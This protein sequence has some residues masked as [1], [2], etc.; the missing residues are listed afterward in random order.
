MVKEKAI[1]R[2]LPA[3]E[4]LGS[5]EVVCT[6]KTG[7]ITKNEL[8]VKEVYSTSNDNTHLY[9]AFLY[10]NNVKDNIGDPLEVSLL[11][12]LKDNKVFREKQGNIIKEYPFSSERKM[13]SIYIN[14]NNE[15][16]LYAKGAYESIIEKCRY[17]LKHNEVI[18]LDKNIKEE[19]E[20]KLES[21]VDKAYRVIAFAYKNDDKEQ[22]LIFLGLVGFIDPPRENISL[23]IELM[24][25]AGIKIV[26]ITGDA[27]KTAYQIAKEVGIVKNR[28]ECIDGS[29][30]DE[31][32][33]KNQPLDKYKVF[34]RVNP[35]HKVKIVEYYKKKNKVVA[36]TGDGVNDAPALKMADVGI[37]MGNGSEVAKSS[38]NIILLDNNFKT[39]EK[40][41]EEGRNIFINIKKAVLFLLSSNLGEVL[42]VVIFLLLRLP[43]PLLSI[44]ILW[45]NLISDS[46]PALALGNERKYDDVMNEKPRKK[47]ESIFEKNGLFI[48]VFYGILIFIIT[49][50]SYLILPVISLI[51]M[52][53]PLNLY[54]VKMVL[55]NQDILNKS[56]TFAF[57][58]LGITQL[59]HMIGMCNIKENIVNILKNK[60]VFRLIA[61]VIG[62]ILQILVTEVPL[63]INI[64]KTYR[65]SFVDWV[66]LI[67][68]SMTP[69]FFHQII[70]KAY[71]EG[72]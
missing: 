37:A 28:D 60:N 61:F 20:S 36:M 18:E 22:N 10:C 71:R 35:S 6:D 12:Y 16:T 24:K 59:F 70:R 42:S 29:K 41:I 5:V 17:V 15:N 63:F 21:F 27:E 9:N 2:K 43:L 72:L 8:E 53:V 54:N 23:S 47:D 51:E 14:C 55:S 11:N 4:T 13:M 46:F 3:V 62:F 1:V 7:T 34:A 44:H 50:I 57:T 68:I 69:L 31:L 58:T 67:L 26:M 66:W 49:S 48:I 64:F 25:K 40:A 38:G 19:I 65:L 45:V 52:K 39:I 56:R 30:L 32:I 33:L